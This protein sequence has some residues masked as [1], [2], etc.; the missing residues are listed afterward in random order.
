MQHFSILNLAQDTAVHAVDLAIRFQESRIVTA[1]DEGLLF[2]HPG[3]QIL[4]AAIIQFTEHV[5][6]QEDGVL[7]GDGGSGGGFGHFQAEHHTALLP[8]AGKHSGL[9]LIHI[10]AVEARVLRDFSPKCTPEQRALIR[11]RA[12]AYAALARAEEIDYNKLYE[13]DRLLH[14][15]WFAAMG[16]M[17]L[18]RTLQNAHADYSRFRMLDTMTSGGLDEVIA[19]HQNIIAAIERCDLAAFEPL[20]E[21]HLYGGIRRLGSKLTEEYADYFEPEK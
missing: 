19:D 7:P 17:Y 5:V 12:D 2:P 13:A 4:L 9:S 20:V 6:Q 10:S 16:K 8:L 3:Q 15:T 18:W 21:R 11:R 1:G 14:E